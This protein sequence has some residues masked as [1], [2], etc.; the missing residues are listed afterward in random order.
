MCGCVC[1]CVCE[2][3]EIKAKDN[4]SGWIPIWRMASNLPTHSAPEHHYQGLLCCLFY[5]LQIFVWLQLISGCTCSSPRPAKPF[6][7]LARAIN[8]AFASP[9]WP[10]H[11]ISPTAPFAKETPCHLVAVSF[12]KPLGLRKPQAKQ[13][14]KVKSSHM[15]EFAYT[16][17]Y[18]R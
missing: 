9:R 3:A 8:N 14:D 13:A 12:F 11:R 4:I 18:D 17:N 5:R 2:T 6:G 1:V 10:R 7:P 15:S 16:R